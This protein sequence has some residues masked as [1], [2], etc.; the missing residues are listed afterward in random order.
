MASTN[1]E[2]NGLIL[3][4]YYDIDVNVHIRFAVRPVQPFRTHAN[5]HHIFQL[6]EIYLY[7]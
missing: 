4:D 2:E 3:S 5:A 1:R 7:F 6:L